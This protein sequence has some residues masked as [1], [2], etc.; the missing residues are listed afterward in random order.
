MSIQ[1]LPAIHPVGQVAN[2]PTQ[3]QA[4]VARGTVGLKPLGSA[5][6]QAIAGRRELRGTPP[7]VVVAANSSAGQALVEKAV[8]HLETL[9]VPRDQLQTK[10]LTRDELTMKHVRFERVMNGKP[11]YGE[12]VV[13]H[14]G[15]GRPFVSGNAQPMQGPSEPTF[16]S[17]R[18]AVLSAIETCGVGGDAAVTA[19]YFRDP[20]SQTYVDG[21][22]VVISGE[23][24]GGNPI[25]VTSLVDGATARV[26]ESCT[27]T[28]GVW[29]PREIE[30]EVGKPTPQPKP[31]ASEDR[32]ADDLTMYSGYVALDTKRAAAGHVLR[33]EGRGLHVETRDAKNG[34]GRITVDF[35]DLNDVWGEGGDPAANKAAVDAHY[36]AQM[37]YDTMWSI[38]GI[39]SIDLRGHALNSRV[40]IRRN[41]ANAYWDGK[42][43]N[44]GDGDGKRVGSLTTLDIAGHEIAHGLTHN[45]S[46]LIYRGESG[47]LNEA[48][49]DVAGTL[50]EWYASRKN[51]AVKW[52]WTVGEKAWTPNNGD[53]NDGLRYM[54]EPTRDKCSVDHYSKY[55][56]Q[57]EVHGSSGIANNAFYQLAETDNSNKKAN[58]V[59]GKRVTG[60]IGIEK[61]AKIF[62]RALIHYMTPRTT[63][64]DARKATIQAATDLHGA[65]SVEVR[66]VK[67]AWS[68]VGV[69]DNNTLMQTVL[70]A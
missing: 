49:S 69:E 2:S 18:Q 13:V 33:D 67:E 26:H 28:K 3:A 63:F 58:S 65:R 47:G 56:Q 53:P 20:E 23:D 61:A 70:H 42:T 31:V 22:Q 55:P 60:G 41:Y 50:V 1:Q 30:V 12:Q 29:K 4:Q 10:M 27:H 5:E 32:R 35:V 11:V 57:T 40:H 24:A 34:D 36:G 48:M 8:S 37:T 66:T 43:M 6:A 16:I 9:G 7:T 39:D 25:T 21:F 62:F 44:Y 38:L 15:S 19:C 54:D 51:S 14:L 17:P 59:S 68:V 52:N 45:T 46:G 64:S